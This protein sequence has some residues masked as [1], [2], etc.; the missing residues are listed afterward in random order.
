MKQ[1][2]WEFSDIVEYDY[3]LAS[4]FDCLKYYIA[5]YLN[6]QITKKI[7]CLKCKSA[8]T[9]TSNFKPKGDL[10]NPKSRGWLK[11]LKPHLHNLMSAI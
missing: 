9:S 5:G 8:L 2:E 7:T 4:I 1:G 6:H 11:H 3:S 10:S